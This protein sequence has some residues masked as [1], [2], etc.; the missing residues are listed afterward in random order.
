MIEP[1]TIPDLECVHFIGRG[2]YGDVWM[3]RTHTEAF[4][5]VKIIHRERFDSDLAF[6]REFQGIK[7]YES[8]AR[9][10]A[11]IDVFHVGRSRSYYY[12]V[13]PLADGV[14]AG[15]QTNPS[16][17][18]PSTLAYK[19]QQGRIR[20]MFKAIQASI[21]L[22]NGL[23]CLHGA[24]LIHRDIKPSNVVFIGNKPVLADIGLI[25]ESELG[26]SQLGTPE[27]VPPEG[28]GHVRGDLYAMGLTM[29]E[30]ITG[31]PASRFP[32]IPEIIGE[33]DAELFSRVNR[34]LLKAGSPN[35][36]QRYANAAKMMAALKSA[37]TPKVE[38]PKPPPPP[39]SRRSRRDTSSRSSRDVVR[40]MSAPD[41][42]KYMWAIAEKK[43]DEYWS[44][45]SAT[46]GV[47]KCR[48]IQAIGLALSKAV[49]EALGNIPDELQ[50]GILF[51]M[52]VLEPRKSRR[53]ALVVQAY[54]AEGLEDPVDD[55]IAG[56]IPSFIP[57]AVTSLINS[58]RHR[59]AKIQSMQA[60]KNNGSE[61]IVAWCDYLQRD[62][63][64]A[65]SQS[66]A[67]LREGLE[68][69]IHN[70]R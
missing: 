56:K 10:P 3:A 23:S 24:H 25:A 30:M 34:I 17:Y 68:L 51:A 22:L 29:Y 7:R 33:R 69:G 47:L 58:V 43:V 6:D 48:H 54:E 41:M 53:R 38:E 20:P 35:P 45:F 21:D 52:A 61:W 4:R 63:E 1:P 49:E 70:N 14:T 55:Y 67:I 64:T 31:L 46:Q 44:T 66:L 65:T 5:A 18:V 15:W 62:P 57:E 42:T 32:D 13:M 12:Y 60:V 2:G 8:A 26:V 27:Y 39:R 9:H 19:L 11:L 36:A 16:S 40:E 37:I 59:A 50:S 28:I